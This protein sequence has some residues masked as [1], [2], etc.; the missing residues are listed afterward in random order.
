MDYSIDIGF[1]SLLDC[2]HHFLGQGDSILTLF[3]VLAILALNRNQ[4][5]M[6][7]IWFAVSL[8]M[9]FQG[10]VLLPL[11]GI[12]SLRR[13]GLQATII[14]IVLGLGLFS[15]VYAPFVNV[16]GWDNAMRPYI[17]AVDQNRVITANAF[18]LWFLL[19]PSIWSLLPLDLNL[20]QPIPL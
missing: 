17:G 11:V 16:S 3:L 15:L 6:A 7:W 14:G 1:S 4:A 12:L 20:F 19:T 10:V 2:R 18:N 9:K 5:R 13:F 8:L